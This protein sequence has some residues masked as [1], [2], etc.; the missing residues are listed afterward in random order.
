MVFGMCTLQYLM[1]MH[2]DFHRDIVDTEPCS[3]DVNKMLLGSFVEE[4]DHENAEDLS[5]PGSVSFLPEALDQSPS[6]HTSYAGPSRAPTM[7]TIR[8]QPPR[9][10]LPN[11][12]AFHHQN[13][14]STGLQSLASGVSYP[15]DLQS[16]SSLRSSRHSSPKE[17]L[18]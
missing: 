18:P 2:T 9:M 7:K 6:N 14:T 5:S 12:E 4:F 17:P 16:Q 15:Q 3:G 1:N 10:A 13:R 11:H 8:E